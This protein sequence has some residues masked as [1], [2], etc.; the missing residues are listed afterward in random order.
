M[1]PLPAP[2]PAH[3]P[4]PLACPACSRSSVWQW[5]R[6]GVALDDG[7]PLTVDR[8]SLE[9]QRELDAMRTQVGVGVGV[10][11]GVEEGVGVG[12]AAWAAQA[13]QVWGRLGHFV[14]GALGGPGGLGL[15][16]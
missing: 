14:A 15:A 6:Y 7:Q 12:V 3:P 5:L 16:G 11:V 4:A 1:H 8:V 13:W 9:I 10:G 2:R